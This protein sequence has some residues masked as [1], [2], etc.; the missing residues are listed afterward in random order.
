[1]CPLDSASGPPV[2]LSIFFN[3]RSPYCYLACFRMFSLLD[4]FDIELDWR[5]LGGWDGRSPPERAASKI[6]LARQ[7]VGRFS[8]RL[9]VPFAPPP[10]ETDPTPAAAVSLYAEEQGLLRPFIR[11]VM[12]KE[13]GEGVD[14]GILETLC[15]V[16]DSIGLDS[17]RVRDAASDESRLVRLT[18]NWEEAKRRGVIGVPSFLV[19]DQIFWGNDRLDFV[20]E[21]LHGLR[22][23]RI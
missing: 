23:R 17:D 21:C 2:R 20:E 9:G 22:L 1:M 6:P 3:F 15:E 8:A 10:R 5:P 13:W 16:G 14:I 18:E 4:E 11:A 7:D 19:G 12:S